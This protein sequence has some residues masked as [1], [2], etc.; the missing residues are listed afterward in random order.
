M[1]YGTA[2]TF[3]GCELHHKQQA[4]CP[5]AAMSAA[6]ASTHLKCGLVKGDSDANLLH[7]A[8]TRR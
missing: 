7:H 2:G 4:A 8:A 6:K 3:A 1:L 5:Q